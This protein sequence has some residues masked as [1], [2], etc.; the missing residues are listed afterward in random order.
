[1][2]LKNSVNI[3]IF[4]ISNQQALNYKRLNKMIKDITKRR[5]YCWKM[6]KLRVFMPKIQLCTWL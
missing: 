5:K 4:S 2:F 6:Y 1:M 3:S